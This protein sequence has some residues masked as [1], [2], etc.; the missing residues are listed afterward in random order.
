[1]LKV[2]RSTT[3][4]DVIDVLGQ[5]FAVRGVPK[6]ICSD[7]GPEFIARAIERRLK[8]V[9]VEMMYVAPGSPW[10]TRPRPSSRPVVLLPLRRHDGLTQPVPS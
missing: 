3:S 5:L 10:G 7:N 4:E 9:D 8:Q 6:R 1:M 2:D